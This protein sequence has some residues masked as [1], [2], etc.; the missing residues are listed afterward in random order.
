MLR[1]AFACFMACLF[2]GM[3]Q[4]PLAAQEKPKEPKPPVLT[5]YLTFDDGPLEGSEDVNDAVRREK[6]K[7]NVFVVGLNMLVQ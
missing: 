6:T 2:I 5:I 1:H 4:L 7:I 3:V